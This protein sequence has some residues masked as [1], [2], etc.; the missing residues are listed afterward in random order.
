MP[1]YRALTIGAVLAMGVATASPLAHASAASALCTPAQE[2][3]AQGNLTAIQKCNAA[4]AASAAIRRVA[5]IDEI[6]LFDMKMDIGVSPA[7]RK[8]IFPSDPKAPGALN[9]QMQAYEAARDACVLAARA[10]GYLCNGAVTFKADTTK[11]D[12]HDAASL[13]DYLAKLRGGDIEDKT[14]NDDRLSAPMRAA[15]EA[16]LVAW[17]TADLVLGGV[18]KDDTCR[19]AVEDALSVSEDDATADDEISAKLRAETSKDVVGA[20]VAADKWEANA[21]ATAHTVGWLH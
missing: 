16:A 5:R 2:Q 19:I 7:S 1:A 15:K 12:A 8:D 9:A 21:T 20:R 4:R 17:Y 18:A 11:L 3:A 13:A 6:T 10:G 14:H